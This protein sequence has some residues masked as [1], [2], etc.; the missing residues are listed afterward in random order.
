MLLI[1]LFFVASLVYLVF[2]TI[3]VQ[4]WVYLLSPRTIHC[5]PVSWTHPYQHQLK[6][7]IVLPTGQSW[8]FLDR[9]SLFHN[10]CSLCQVDIKLAVL[11]PSLTLITNEPFVTENQFFQRHWLLAAHLHHVL[12]LS[13]PWEADMKHV[14]SPQDIWNVH[15]DGPHIHTS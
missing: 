3:P 4:G 5:P 14:W 6:C 8:H 10:E 1:A 11:W 7:I 2:W 15:A 9:G 13:L 12:G